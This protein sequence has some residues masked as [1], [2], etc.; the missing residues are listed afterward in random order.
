MSF[1]EKF[2]LRETKR[3]VN[4][5]FMELEQLEWEQARL[6]VQRGL[7]ANHDLAYDYGQDYISVGRDEFNF[8]AKEEKTEELEKHL[9]GYNWAKSVLSEKEQRY[10][11]EYFLNRKYEDEIVDLLGFGSSD[12][13]AF[14]ELKRKAVY[15]FAYV[16]NLVV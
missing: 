8:V 14:K 2:D 9:A 1:G 13:R 12:S 7:T 10:I 5:Y 4:H 16:L 6:N 3:N 11:L 15:K